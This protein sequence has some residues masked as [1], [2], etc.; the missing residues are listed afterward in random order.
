[1]LIERDQGTI[2]KR[3]AEPDEAARLDRE[4]V[5]LAEARH[6]GVVALLDSGRDERG[7]WLRLE[8]VGDVTLERLL[9]SESAE[10]L[11]ALLS[12][13]AT[14]IADLHDIGVV[15]GA[16][17]PSHV[18]VDHDGR[19]LLCGFSHGGHR[20][21]TDARPVA[22]LDTRLDVAALGHLIDLLLGDDLS[23]ELSDCLD[24][25]NDLHAR[26]MPS[27]RDLSDVLCRAAHRRPK[28]PGN[29][30]RVLKP[31][32]RD[33]A[34]RTHRRPP[35]AAIA[36][37]ATGGLL[38]LG[39]VVASVAFRSS[40]PT[41]RSVLAQASLPGVPYAYQGGV[42]SL[43]GQRF[44]VGATGDQ[45]TVGHW[46]C[47]TLEVALLRPDGDIYLFDHL[48]RKGLDQEGRLIAR[49]P[50]ATWLRTQ[51]AARPGC[52]LLAVGNAKGSAVV[53]PPAA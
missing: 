38:V 23:P 17:D 9:T 47:A 41:R 21:D 16:I 39:L 46:S 44:A 12:T 48:A 32:P 28:W 27:A 25:T 24:R 40:R 43:S 34:G 8:D 31:R 11:L 10:G 50:G 4:A 22:R 33:P 37:L 52:D 19:P 18:L 14:T 35:Q 15:H 7:P 3:P 2:V 6:A 30:P 45:L 1:M 29:S 5:L 36:A 51:P 20:G 26:G 49:A 53:Q 13:V 42:L